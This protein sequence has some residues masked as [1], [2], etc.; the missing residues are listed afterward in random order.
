MGPHSQISRGGRGDAAGKDASRRGFTLLEV[1]VSAALLMIVT[2]MSYSI[3]S[4]ISSAWK[5]HKA[6]LGAFEGARVAF[7]LLTSRLSQATL[8]TYWDYNDPAKPT[9]YLRQSELHFVMGRGK[10]LLPSGVTDVV[11]DAVFFVAPLG[12][13]TETQFRPLVKM[14]TACGFFVRFSAELNRPA[15]LGTRVPERYRYRLFQFLQPGEQLGIYASSSGGSWFSDAVAQNAFPMVDNVIGLILRANYPTS[16]GERSDYAYDSR[17][18]GG[19]PADPP[20]NF[21]Q[22]PPRVSVTMVVIDEDSARR[23]AG[24]YGDTAPPIGPEPS[25]LFTTPAQYESDLIAWENQL[26]SFN[27]RINYR[28]LTAEIPIRGAKWS[29]N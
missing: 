19:S 3:I 7:E 21:H 17:D 5:G 20:P 1:L 2:L 18:D 29:S 15:F 16:S 25:T 13:T 10:D 27:P 4:S 12:F 22:L 14:L 26:K 6:R 24:I 11:G 28:I 23:L 8:N 9:R